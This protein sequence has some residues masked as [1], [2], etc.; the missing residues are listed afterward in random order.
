LPDTADIQNPLPFNLLGN[1]FFPN[2]NGFPHQQNRGK[3]TSSYGK[4]I[5][6]QRESIINDRLHKAE[7]LF[8]PSTLSSNQKKPR[9]KQ[10][11]KQTRKIPEKQGSS[12]CSCKAIFHY[13]FSK[14]DGE[15][16]NQRRSLLYSISNH[17]AKNRDC[18]PEINRKDANKAL[19]GATPFPIILSIKRY[20]PKA[21][22]TG[23]KTMPMR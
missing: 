13:E 8:A 3:I 7:G 20:S 12:T 21:N 22:P 18:K 10:L 9:R 19:V 14:E 1:D 2:H 5:N 17:M 16:T 11:S 4:R 6:Q 23:V 15:L